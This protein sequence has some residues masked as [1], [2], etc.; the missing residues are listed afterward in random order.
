MDTGLPSDQFDGGVMAYGLRN[1]SS[2]F[3]G[4]M[5]LHR[6]LKPGGR[7]GI[8]DF[9]PLPIGSKRARFQKLYLRRIVVPI[10]SQVGL[11]DHYAYLEESLKT[12]PDGPAQADM[13]RE[14]GFTEA[15]HR[16]LAAGQM[17]ALLL[18][19]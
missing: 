11:H 10:A 19:S 13:A 6:L 2:P 18:T 17:G 5:E 16:P 12:F 4:L 8:L 15:F 3:K 9:N 14:A 7:A 1:L